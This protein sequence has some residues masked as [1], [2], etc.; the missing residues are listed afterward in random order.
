MHIDKFINF[1]QKLDIEPVLLE[2]ILSG[3]QAVFHESINAWNPNNS[4]YFPF[5]NPVGEPMGSYQRIMKQLPS[6]IGATGNAGDTTRAGNN[7][8]KYFAGLP[9]SHRDIKEETIK[10]WEDAPKFPKIKK[11]PSNFIKKV[12]KNAQGH[13]PDGATHMVAPV[14]YYTNFH[15]GMY[16]VDTRKPPF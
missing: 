5:V 3:F 2:S 9:G 16:D 14:N 1:L 13:I 12:L 6:S 4:P 15:M 11:Q 7:E 10:E 8:Y